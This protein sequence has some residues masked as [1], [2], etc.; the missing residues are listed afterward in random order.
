MTR[1]RDDHSDLGA[2]VDELTA[3][4]APS[5]RR[6][7]VVDAAL[8]FVD[9]SGYTALTERLA[10]LGR[11][12]SE[13]L[14]DIVNTCFERL[15]D[16]VI[17]ADG[18]V[19]RFG[20]DALFIAFIGPDR[21]DRAAETAVAMQRTIRG[22]PA[23]QAPGG[24]VRLSQSIGLHRGDLLLHRWSGSWTEVVP[25]GP[26][27]TEV[28]RCEAAAH[29]GQIAISDTVVADL[30]VTRVRR[31]SDG[32]ALLRNTSRPK[33]EQTP[34]TPTD[35]AAWKLRC[36]VGPQVLAPSVRNAVRAGV[37]PAHRPAAI[38]F[39]AV[40]GLDRLAGNPAEIKRATDTLFA[41]VDEASSALDVT[42]ISTDVAPDGIKLIIAA[43]VPATVGDDGERLVIALERIVA[44]TDRLDVRAGANIGVVFAADVGHPRRR[45][46]TVMGDAVNLSA[47]LAYRAE[48]GA[49]LASAAL[50]DTLPSRFRVGWVP[51]FTVKGKR[52]AQMAAVVLST[53]A[54]PIGP[55][56]SGATLAPFRGRRA[57]VRRLREAVSTSP[58][59]EVFGPAGF[60]SSRIVSEVLDGHHRVTTLQVDVIDSSTPLLAVR[61][62]V[63]ALG[64]VGAWESI[65]LEAFGRRTKHIAARPPEPG[66]R[67]S[68]ASP[69]TWRSC[70]RPNSSW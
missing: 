26:A 27:V 3:T 11:V 24:R 53:D 44:A 4:T 60:G 67:Q 23:I 57:E 12:G 35:D 63:E 28:L 45:T 61:R 52:A 8:L 5:S 43:G 32:V 51:S 39:V 55:V 29:A 14:T 49:V 34:S 13:M 64:G 33:P 10:A 37:E 2:Y 68:P 17:A 18:H 56:D 70:G 46:Y 47:R 69:A 59:I 16:D 30:G 19:L 36:S 62:L 15:I 25:Y 7:R 65:S 50:V 22:L 48:P 58:V 1:A 38:G 9:V 41:A 31:R 21:L 66:S 40:S 54:D 6:N 42:L 20:G